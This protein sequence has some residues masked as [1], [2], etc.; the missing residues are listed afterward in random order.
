MN[1]VSFFLDTNVLVYTFDKTALEKQATAQQLLERALA[2]DGCISFQVM[3]EFLNL[4][5]RKFDPPLT[6]AQAKRYVQTTLEPLCLVY[7]DVDLYQRALDVRERWRFSFYDS[8]IVAA[9]L[10]A[11]CTIL[12]SEDLQ[13]NQKVEA[14]TIINPFF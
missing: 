10:E 7:A 2:G 3:Q 13:H 6:I 4:A 5:L 11:H 1:G 14:L 12:Y 8:L 9:A